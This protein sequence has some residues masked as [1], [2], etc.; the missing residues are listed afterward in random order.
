MTRY[1]EPHE[2]NKHHPMG[3]E[4]LTAFVLSPNWS[5]KQAFVLFELLTDMRIHLIAQYRYEFDELLRERHAAS[6]TFC[7]ADD[8]PF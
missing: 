2:P 4:Y 7:V 8:P 5:A 3:Y 1:H 6:N